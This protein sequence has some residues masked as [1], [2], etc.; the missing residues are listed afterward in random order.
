[1]HQSAGRDRSGGY[2]LG[3]LGKVHAFNRS[4]GQCRKVVGDQWTRYG[5]STARQSSLN[6]HR[7]GAQLDRRRR[8]HAWWRIF[9]SRGPT[10][11]CKLNGATDDDEANGGVSRMSGG[12]LRPRGRPIPRSRRLLLSPHR[13]RARP[14][15]KAEPSIVHPARFTH[16]LQRVDP[17]AA[18]A[19]PASRNCAIHADQ[20]LCSIRR[21]RR[22]VGSHD[23][24]DGEGWVLN[25]SST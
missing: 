3:Y 11:A 8:R 21:A 15:D 18:S 24:C 7:V 20:R 12:S 17:G 13:P 6:R 25:S 2:R 1:M 10:A 14:K 16:C 5:L 4:A 19:N 9:R 22:S 23:G